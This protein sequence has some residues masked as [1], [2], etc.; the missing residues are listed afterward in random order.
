MHSHTCAEESIRN[1]KKAS[2]YALCANDLCSA[3]AERWHQLKVY[4]GAADEQ[5]RGR[6]QLHEIRSTPKGRL[7]PPNIEALVPTRSQGLTVFFKI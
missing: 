3:Q 1:I 5:S 6:P 4:A 7:S 2:P